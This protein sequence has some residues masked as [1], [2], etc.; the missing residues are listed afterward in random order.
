MMPS[1]AEYMRL[2]LFPGTHLFVDSN[3]NEGT[4]GARDVHSRQDRMV[5]L[6]FTI[7]PSDKICSY[8]LQALDT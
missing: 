8:S 5:A 3:R 7:S 1:G 6:R 4:D 2:E